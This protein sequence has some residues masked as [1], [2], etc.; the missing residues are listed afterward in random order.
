MG[1]GSTTTEMTKE[2]KNLLL[3]LCLGD[4][5]LRKPFLKESGAGGCSVL[6]IAH[7]HKQLDYL[8]WKASLLEEILQRPV[9]IH[10][11]VSRTK[12]KSYDAY[13]IMIG[14]KYFGILRRYLYRNGKKNFTPTMMSRLS[15]LGWAIWYLDDGCLYTEKSGSV[16]TSLSLGVSQQEADIVANFIYKKFGVKFSSFKMNG[17]G[18]TYGIETRT[19]QSIKFIEVV[20]RPVEQ[21][22]K[23]LTY[24]VRFDKREAILDTKPFRR[25]P[26]VED[27]V[28]S[29]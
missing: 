4:G 6:T 17:G 29:V 23:C 3:A 12:V 1:Q 20:R 22:I 14:H 19:E 27:I 18:G 10:K 13:R 24:K 9:K 2:H 15:P 7:S 16:T 28:Y 5:N 26:K 8:K 21:H 11:C 25:L